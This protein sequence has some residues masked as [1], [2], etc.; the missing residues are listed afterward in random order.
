LIVPVVIYLLLE[1][2]REFIGPAG[3]LGNHVV[4]CRDDG[5]CVLMAHLR[6]GSLRVHKGDRVR[7]GDQIAECGNSGNSS[8]PHLH[9]QV[10][11]RPSVWVAAGLPFRIDGTPLPRNGGILTAA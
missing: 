8:E 11:D 2:V 1:S 5:L 4:V 3:V 9:C 10:M 7:R 6:R